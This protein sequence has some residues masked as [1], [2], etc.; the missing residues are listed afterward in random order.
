MKHEILITDT[1][2]RYLC[3]ENESV[4]VGM[5]RL[6]R[7][8]IPLG[9]RG[10]GCGVCKVEVVEGRYHAQVMSRAHIREEEIAAGQVLACRIRPQSP[11]TVRVVGGL[12]K[13]ACRPRPEAGVI[14]EA[15]E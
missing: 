11:L 12:R 4:L 3:D 10:G 1:G 15:A 7:K 8:G 2:E 13:A 14:A 5:A 6:G 9:C